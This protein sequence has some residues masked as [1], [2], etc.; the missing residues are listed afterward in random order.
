M[1]LM[2]ILSQFVCADF[3]FSVDMSTYMFV[4]IHP[5]YKM[6]WFHDNMPDWVSDMKRLFTETVTHL[7]CIS[8]SPSDLIW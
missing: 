3:Y 5:S 6:Q 2:L 4:V 7:I 8:Y 1:M